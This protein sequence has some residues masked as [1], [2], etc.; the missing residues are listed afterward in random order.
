MLNENMELTSSSENQITSHFYTMIS[1]TKE[2]NDDWSLY[3]ALLLK[4][5][6]DHQQLD[7]NL[8]VK[9]KN[10]V[11]FGASYRTSP[12]EGANEAFGPSFYLELT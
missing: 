3:P 11:W 9:L 6:E 4:T 8:N 7:V 12:D 10:K 2:L 5:T 1:Y